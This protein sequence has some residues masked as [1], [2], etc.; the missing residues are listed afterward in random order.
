[1]TTIPSVSDSA[2]EKAAELFQ[3]GQYSKVIDNLNASDLDPL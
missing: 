2:F 1:M 3:Q